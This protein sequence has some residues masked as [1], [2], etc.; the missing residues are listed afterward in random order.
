MGTHVKMLLVLCFVPPESAVFYFDAFVE[1]YPG[2]IDYFIN[3]WK[4]TYIGRMR[5]N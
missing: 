5:R 1:D 2:E 4:D 3:Y